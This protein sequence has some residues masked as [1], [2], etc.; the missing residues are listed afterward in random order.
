MQKGFMYLCA[1]MDVYSR[2]FVGWS[3]DNGMDTTWVVN[4]LKEAIKNNGKPEIINSDQGTQ[5][6]SDEY[7]SFLKE[8]GIQISMDGKGRATDSAFIERFVR[9]IKYDKLY[10]E[11]PANGLELYDDRNDFINYYNERRSHSK[12]GKRPPIERYRQV[13]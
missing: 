11:P 13:A 3:V 1:I 4:T 2:Y 8:Q 6:T 7:T 10:L 12:A 5:F 9:T